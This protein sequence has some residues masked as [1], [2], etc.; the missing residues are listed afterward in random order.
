[1]P[2]LR[3]RYKD[4]LKN[5]WN[6]GKILFKIY[7]NQFWRQTGNVCNGRNPKSFFKQY[8]TTNFNIGVQHNINNGSLDMDPTTGDRFKNELGQYV[9]YVND[10]NSTSLLI[11]TNNTI[12]LDKKK[13]WFLG[14]IIF[15]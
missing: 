7:Q 4:I 1:M 10:T 8:W 14:L 9:T 13:T 3:F 5:R 6:I 12:R 15:T 11:Q 2:L